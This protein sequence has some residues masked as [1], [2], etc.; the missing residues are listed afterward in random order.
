[1][2][3]VTVSCGTVRRALGA[4]AL[5]ALEP[6]EREEVEAHLVGCPTC[7]EE[8]AALTATAQALGHL[9]ATDALAAGEEAGRRGLLGRA[10]AELARRRRRRRRRLAGVGVALVLA[11]AGGAAGITLAIRPAAPQ[12]VA[13]TAHLSGTDPHSG[14][15]AE[16]DIF[17]KS[18]GSSIHMTISGV[19][20]GERC[21]LVAVSRDGSQEVAGGWHVDYSGAAVIDGATGMPPAQLASLRVVTRHGAMLITLTMP[22]P[23][24]R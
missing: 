11:A 7:R 15:T 2:D 16:A 24:S 10:L 3:A 21:E 4:H 23:P 5:R 18:W 12:A 22:S 8:L 19:S 20:P 9:A 17:A 1:M 6:G 14:V 13:A